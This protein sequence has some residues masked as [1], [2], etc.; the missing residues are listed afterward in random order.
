M[1]KTRQIPIFI[2]G[3]MILASLGMSEPSI[4]FGELLTPVLVEKKTTNTKRLIEETKKAVAAFPSGSTGFRAEEVEGE[5]AANDLLPRQRAL[6]TKETALVESTDASGG[7]MINLQGRFQCGL[8]V[9]HKS[10]E[11][12]VGEPLAPAIP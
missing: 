11:T 4:S 1:R 10:M 7:T 3:G 9:P 12:S 6:S 8:K 5:Q 2:F